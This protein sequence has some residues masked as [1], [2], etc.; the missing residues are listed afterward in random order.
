MLFYSYHQL[1]FIP[2]REILSHP[3]CASLVQQGME[4]TVRSTRNFLQI[5]EPLRQSRGD[6]ACYRNRL[7]HCL[8]KLLQIL[9]ILS[10]CGER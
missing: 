1:G 3:S 2:V 9:E 5:V 7:Y 8:P 10:L 6:W 4:Y